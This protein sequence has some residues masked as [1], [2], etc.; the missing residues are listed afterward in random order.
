MNF[1]LLTGGS[2]AVTLEGILAYLFP[3]RLAVL[4]RDSLKD[5]LGYQYRITRK[6]E[7]RNPAA[8]AGVQIVAVRESRARYVPKSGTRESRRQPVWA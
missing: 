2:K 7:V 4:D 6:G 8:Y 1:I 3:P 5:S